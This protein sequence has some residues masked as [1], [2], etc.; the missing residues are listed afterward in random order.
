[1]LKDVIMHIEKSLRKAD[2]FCMK[3]TAFFT[4]INADKTPF[5]TEN[6]IKTLLFR[7][8]V[9]RVKLFFITLQA[10]MKIK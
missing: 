4:S 3:K 10:K 8:K 5:V 7:K 1:M 2:S 9:W 6:S